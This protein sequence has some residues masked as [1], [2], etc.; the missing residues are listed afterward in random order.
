MQERSI[1]N[2]TRAHL[3]TDSQE[4]SLFPEQPPTA[5][6]GCLVGSAGPELQANPASLKPFHKIGGMP[7]RLLID[8]GTSGR[9]AHFSRAKTLLQRTGKSQPCTTLKHKA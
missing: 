4:G 9:V 8:R 1:K 2:S 3:P 7:R 5:E 6:P